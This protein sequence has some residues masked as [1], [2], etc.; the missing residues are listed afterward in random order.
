M[1]WKNIL[2]FDLFLISSGIFF[3]EHNGFFEK[4]LEFKKKYDYECT[5]G[6]TGL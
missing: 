5:V 1:F 6:K 4:Y 3:W 2:E